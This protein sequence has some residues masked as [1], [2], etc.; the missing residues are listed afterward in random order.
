MGQRKGF[1]FEVGDFAQGP[2]Y[3]NW[4][5]ASCMQDS[6]WEDDGNRFLLL[7]LQF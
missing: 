6:Q 7:K 1:V 3:F 2:A 4:P 5:T